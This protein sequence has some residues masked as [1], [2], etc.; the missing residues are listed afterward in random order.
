MGSLSVSTHRGLVHWQGLLLVVSLLNFWSQPTTTQV[1]V[2][3]I[4]ALEGTDVLLRI[5]YKPPNV[6]GLI[7][8]RG[9]STENNRIIASLTV[10]SRIHKR[11]LQVGRVKLNYDGSLMLKNVTMKDSGIY[12]LVIRLQDC[13][14]T[15]ESTR[16]TVYP[17]LRAPTLL[18]S[19]T[20]VTANKDA[21]V[22]TCQT[23]AHAIHWLFNGTNLQL[24]ERMKL[25][26]DLR[27]LTIDPVLR[28]DAGDYQCN[29][30]NPMNSAKSAS[31]ALDVKFE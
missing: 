15:T 20:T 16:L 30:F 18:A 2:E 23:N 14:S 22:M 24:T 10:K 1:T 3:S 11:G 28:E 19:N 5:L 25:S 7:W 12:T 26:L 8:Y 13:T 27:N 9:Y 4:N 6:A 29:T 21:V 31:L 17:L